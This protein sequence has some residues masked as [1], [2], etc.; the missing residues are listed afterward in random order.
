MAWIWHLSV[1]LPGE[2]EARDFVERLD[3]APFRVPHAGHVELQTSVEQVQSGWEVHVLP[4]VDPE[5]PDGVS[6][7][8]PWHLNGHGSARTPEEVADIDAASAVLYDRLRNAPSLY[9]FALVGFE[10]GDW[11]SAGGL[12]DDLSPGGLYHQ[13]R[14]WGLQTWDGLVVH[15]DLW[16][17][18]WSPGGFEHFSGEYMWTPP[19]SEARRR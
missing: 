8:G 1:S 2:R 18:A 9:R 11:R 15:Q 5:S 6:H 16:R 4:Y 13:H 7:G 3:K 19:T 14:S 10:V 17:A 12:L